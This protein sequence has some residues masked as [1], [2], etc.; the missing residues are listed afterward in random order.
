M[1]FELRNILRSEQST[2]DDE[3]LQTLPLVLEIALSS[4]GT[5]GLL[6]VV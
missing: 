5:G 6:V 2:I 3:N 1:G 4:P